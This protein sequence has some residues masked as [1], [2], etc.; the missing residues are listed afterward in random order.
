MA[1]TTG[2][3]PVWLVQ[4]DLAS[5]VIGTNWYTHDSCR[6]ICTWS[7]F[8]RP[9][10]VYPRVN[11]KVELLVGAPPW[12]TAAC[13]SSGWIYSERFLQR[14]QQFLSHVNPQEEEPVV[15]V[16]DGHFLG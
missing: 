7:Y 4:R 9:V 14:F 13:P 5:T 8:V 16:L 15:L 1:V 2:T 11:M 12:A 10:L 3:S 6:C